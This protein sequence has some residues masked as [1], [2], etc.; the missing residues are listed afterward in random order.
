MTVI[1][2]RDKRVAPTASGSP[3]APC[4]NCSTNSSRLGS[5]RAIVNIAFTESLQDTFAAIF[6]HSAC[7][8]SYSCLRAGSIKTHTKFL[9]YTD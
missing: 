6:N 9:S 4:W 2:V 1:A 3:R 5:A 8:G 7:F